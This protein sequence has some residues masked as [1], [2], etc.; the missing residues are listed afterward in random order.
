MWSIQMIKFGYNGLAQDY[1]KVL[2]HD[3]EA[4]NGYCR[5][6]CSLE[7][8]METMMPKSMSCCLDSSPLEII[9]GGNGQSS[10]RRPT[11]PVEN[12]TWHTFVAVVYIVGQA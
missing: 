9:N 11:C 2:Y 10:A 3:E 5:L 4:T 7:M 6:T 1:D 8:E 12:E